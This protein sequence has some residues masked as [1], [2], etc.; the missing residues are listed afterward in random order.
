MLL[1]LLHVS[2]TPGQLPERPS[3]RTFGLKRNDWLLVR[4]DWILNRWA[5]LTTVFVFATFQVL[6]VQLP[7]NLAYVWL[8]VSCIWAA[9]LTLAP[10]SREDKFRGAAWSCTLPV[11]RPDLVKARYI[12][13][14]L[15]AVGAYL[16]AFTVAMLAPG[17]KI[18]AAFALDPDTLLLVATIIGTILAIMLPSIVRFGVKGVLVL[19]V[20]VNILLPIVFVVSKAM[21]AQDDVEG[22]VIAGLQ[23]LAAM[24][25]GVRDGLSRPLFYLAVVLLLLAANWA[26][27]RFAVALFLRREL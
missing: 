23:T 21:G 6:F 4:R 18:S 17:S 7:S 19:L 25:G 15:L 20:P 16:V 12:G 10:L 22:N 8:F 26:S 14:W 3:Q 13:A 27:Y 11:S 5:I 2:A 24:I 1:S 9:A